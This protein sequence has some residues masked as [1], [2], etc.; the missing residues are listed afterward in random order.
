MKIPGLKSYWVLAILI[1]LQSP[2]FS[3]QRMSKDSA[4]RNTFR[5]GSFAR[6]SLSY[7]SDFVYAGRKDSVAL[8]YSTASLG[9]FHKSGLFAQGFLSYLTSSDEQRVDMTGLTAG[10]MFTSSM[11]YA[12]A[13]GTAWF[14]NDSSYSVQS[15]TGG[16]L[17]AYAGYDFD[18][19]DLTLDATTLF[20]ES[21]DFLAGIE[22]SRM[23]FMANDKFKL[24]PS[25]YT[26]FGTQ[27]Y[28]NEY[29]TYRRTGSTHRGRGPG[30]GMGGGDMMPESEV[31]SQFSL[32]AY[33]FSMP[34]SYTAGKFRFFFTPTYVI[35][36]NPLV[37]ITD[38]VTETESLDNSFYWTLGASYSF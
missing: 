38:D 26:L 36:K 5:R 30:G 32:L 10:Y 17:Y 25:M 29:F 21:T 16:N 23:F 35:P 7:S 20:S 4:D 22:L 15:E 9:Y 28:Y 1:A 37:I 6:V 27:N 2:L 18:V 8:P 3:Q 13:S 24:T 14:Y 31:V 33:E 34:A 11:F 12:G 19:L